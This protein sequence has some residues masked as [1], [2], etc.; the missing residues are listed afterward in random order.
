MI[1]IHKK[2]VLFKYQLFI[3]V[4]L[5][6]CDEEI[7]SDVKFPDWRV[8]PPVDDVNVSNFNGFTGTTGEPLPKKVFSYSFFV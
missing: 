5:S 6:T 3:L 7:V 4:A 2:N 1:I 8:P